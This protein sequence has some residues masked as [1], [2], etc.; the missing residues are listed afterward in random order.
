[1]LRR[2]EAIPSAFCD[3]G[4]GSAKSLGPQPRKGK[5]LAHY[6]IDCPLFPPLI[7]VALEGNGASCSG[8]AL[9]TLTLE[10]VIGLPTFLQLARNLY[11]WSLSGETSQFGV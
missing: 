9:A 6:Q 7:I 5:R 10:E 8:I 1:M 4:I 3:A 11:P 2:P